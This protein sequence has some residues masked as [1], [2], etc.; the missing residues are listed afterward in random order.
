[1]HSHRFLVLFTFLFLVVYNTFPQQS[2]LK[3]GPMVGYGQMTEVMLWVQTT[4]PAAVQ[5]RYWDAAAPA[6]KK[7]STS[8]RTTADQAFIAHV[9]IDGLP[10]GKKFGYELLIDG[11]PV[12]R[13]YP[14]RFQT[15]PLWQW[16]TDPP[17]FAAAFGSCLYINEPEWDRPGKPYGS[18]YEVLATLASKNPDIMLWLGDNTYYREI[19]W[20]TA[21]G[22]RHRWTH[23]RSLPELQPILGATHNYSIWDDHDYGPNDAD[24]SYHL[25]AEALENHKLFWANQQ[26]GTAET[27]G[28]FYRFEWADVEFFMLDDRYHRSPNDSPN[29]DQKTM[30]GKAQLQ[31]LKDCLASSLA[32]FKIIANGNQVLNPA[33]GGE[34]FYD[35]R[36]EYDDL[37][38]FIKTQ[39]IS[40]VVFLSGDRHLT[41]LVALNDPGFYTLYDY[42]NSS[43]TAGL[44]SFKDT[45]N[46]HLVP[47]TLVNDAHNFGILRFSG[48]RKD[49]VLSMECWDYTGKLRWTH[50]V[51]ATELTVKK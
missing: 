23:T 22:L 20:H 30:F 49:R 16:R 17:D 19:D 33:T 3:S 48:P 24:R 45:A 51:K 12:K 39:K 46:V 4:R 43:L 29:D 44:S 34:T 40:G 36:A 13:P 47:G 38:Q 31:W 35:Y 7:L 42:T 8:V 26:Y 27:P 18:D 10:P 6:A 21:A 15:L 1:M 25:K 28:A 11:K 41:E 37:L 50:A 2:A 5:F 14:L 32:T 9:L